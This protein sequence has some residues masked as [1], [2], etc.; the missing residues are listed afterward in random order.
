MKT[1]ILR[2]SLLT[3]AALVALAPAPATA[4]DPGACWLRTSVAEAMDRPSPLGAVAIEMA[5]GTAQLCYGRPSARERSVFGGLVP[6]DAAWRLGANEATALHLPFAATIG[7]HDGVEV[8]AG[9]YSLYVIPTEDSW[10]FVVNG[11]AERW[12]VPIN[13]GV[14]EAD[15]GQVEVPVAAT[16]AMVET[17]TAAWERHG[18]GMGHL[19]FEWENTRVELPI[20]AAGEMSPA[21]N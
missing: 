9:V 13:A 7:G 11:Q 5:E 16:D 3:A 1:T 14:R 17:L 4:Q 8:E 21:A 2:S 20:H 15:L 18:E 10:T 19:V 12:G 6:F